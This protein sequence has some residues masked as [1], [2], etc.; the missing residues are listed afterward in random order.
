VNDQVIP[1]TSDGDILLN[2]L[3]H[4]TYHAATTSLRYPMQR[5][6]R[7]EPETKVGPEDWVVILPAM[8]SGS[9]DFKETPIGTLQGGYLSVTLMNS[10]LQ[11]KWL[12]NAAIWDQT[13]LVLGILLNSWVALYF[14]PWLYFCFM[15]L[16]VTA[17]PLLALHLFLEQGLCLAWVSGTILGLIPGLIVGLERMRQESAHSSGLLMSLRGALAP[18]IAESI[19]KDP[20]LLAGEPREQIVTIMF[21]DIVGFSL[22]TE[23]QTPRE[24]FTQLRQQ[25]AEIIERIHA[26]QGVVDKSL[27]DGVLAYFGY[28][29]GDTGLERGHAD[30]AVQCAE[31]IQKAALE[32]ALLAM[33]QK[34]P[35]Y[36]LRIG[37]NTATVYLGNLGT[38]GRIDFTL[39]GNGVNLSS[40]FEHACRPFRILM[41]LSTF[42]L[43]AQFS[44]QDA[45]FHQR[46][47]QIKHH[48]LPMKCVEF[49]PLDSRED[50]LKRVFRYYKNFHRIASDEQRW[51]IP[52]KIEI[53][54]NWGNQSARLLNFS[55]GG[56]AIQSSLDLTLD[57]AIRIQ[58]QCHHSSFLSEPIDLLPCWRKQADGG[59]YIFGCAFLRVREQETDQLVR[60]LRDLI[61]AAEGQEQLMAR[62][63]SSK[64]VS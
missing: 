44:Q 19:I 48:K 51:N 7:G 12:F 27:G 1:L 18:E 24:A 10:I 47:I 29:Y 49:H 13:F 43:L 9:T 21:I 16:W 11:K 26:F 36:P 45:R 53:F 39:I 40:R 58:I 59:L 30:R 35:V 46:E 22:T 14:R 57:Q 31:A 60:D 63:L 50:Q 17:A 34:L 20:S 3:N 32:R 62:G 64:A 2:F 56:M 25:L 15:A 42:D 55:Q 54:V 6:V 28:H 33:D 4:R 61:R 38:D 52:E 23:R 37:L 41:G 5:I 8:F